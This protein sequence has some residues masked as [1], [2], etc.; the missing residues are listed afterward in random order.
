MRYLRYTA[1]SRS[2]YIGYNIYSRV[3]KACTAW[4]WYDKLT[5]VTLIKNIITNFKSIVY[6]SSLKICI[7]TV[8]IACFSY[9][10]RKLACKHHHNWSSFIVSSSRLA[11]W[12]MRLAGGG[13][14]RTATATYRQ[15]FT[16]TTSIQEWHS[17][18]NVHLPLFINLL[19]STLS[20]FVFRLPRRTENFH[21]IIIYFRL[22]HL[23]ATNMK[24]PGMH[25]QK[26]TDP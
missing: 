20:S 17:T 12:L 5:V 22:F 13:R 7:R 8:Q 24:L 11:H 19:Y 16:T 25:D 21:S 14:G 1:Y 10:N 3:K 18:R 15:W 4:W 2:Q 23:V 9:C 26:I 6:Y